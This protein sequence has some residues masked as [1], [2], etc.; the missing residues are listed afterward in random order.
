M[1]NPPALEVVVSGYDSPEGPAFDARGR[2][3]FVNWLSGAIV[4]VDPEGRAAEVANTGGVPAGLAFH[5]D[6]TL[7]VARYH[8]DGSGV[9]I[10]LLL[11]TPT[12]PL[13]PSDIASV[14]LA[15]LGSDKLL[16]PAERP[17]HFS[18]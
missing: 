2:L 9:W 16:E 4:R 13:R 1:A 14:E 18:P 3:H 5:R 10:P 11:T 15:A 7:Y 6:G 12:N 17:H 8:P